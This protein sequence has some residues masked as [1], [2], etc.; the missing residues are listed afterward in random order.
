MKEILQKI[1]R[2]FTDSKYRFNSMVKIGFYNN[3]DD[4]TF[5]KKSFYTF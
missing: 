4:E 2:F 1:M 5:I 3:M